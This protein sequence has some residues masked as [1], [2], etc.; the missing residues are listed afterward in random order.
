MSIARPNLMRSIKVKF[1]SDQ[2][3]SKARFG[4]EV[5]E[6]DLI[7][8]PEF[9]GLVQKYRLNFATKFLSRVESSPSMV[10]RFLNWPVQDVIEA[11]AE[12]RAQLHHEIP[13][14][15]EDEASFRNW[16]ASLPPMG[17]H[18]PQDGWPTPNDA[19]D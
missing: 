14:Q 3:L 4:T 7:L 19:R 16:Q 5:H 12:L 10:A 17:V 8:P 13:D 18:A 11:A 2:H 9:K 6:D 1:G 15:V